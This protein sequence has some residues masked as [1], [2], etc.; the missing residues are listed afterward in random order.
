MGRVTT[1]GLASQVTAKAP[2]VGGTFVTILVHH[3]GPAGAVAR[4]PITVTDAPRALGEQ[5]ALLVASTAWVGSG[6]SKPLDKKGEQ[7]KGPLPVSQSFL[8]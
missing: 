6:G 2:E 8:Q 7:G 3:I 1:A 5:S 4:S